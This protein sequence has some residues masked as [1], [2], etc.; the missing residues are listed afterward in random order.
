MIV[1]YI[2]TN[3]NSSADVKLLLLKSS[4]GHVL[5][6]NLHLMLNFDT[7]KHYFPLNIIE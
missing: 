1:I 7:V 3:L 2:Y 5:V 4:S 6:Q